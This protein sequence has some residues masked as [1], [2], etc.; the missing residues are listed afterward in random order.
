[1]QMNGSSASYGSKS[2]YLGSPRSHVPVLL[3]I[4]LQHVLPATIDARNV[5]EPVKLCLES[6]G[7][8][9]YEERPFLVE[10]IGL[11]PSCHVVTRN[12]MWTIHR[13]EDCIANPMTALCIDLDSV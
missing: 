13:N 10:A 9:W 11:A 4:A 7:A 2:R 3:I 12:M 8:I 6:D 1:M 5:G